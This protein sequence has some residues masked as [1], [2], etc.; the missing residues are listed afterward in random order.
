MKVDDPYVKHMKPGL[1]VF[2]AIGAL[3]PESW[4]TYLVDMEYYKVKIPF[5]KIK[6]PCLM[7]HGDC[8]DDIN[9]S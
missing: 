7:I 6:T 8:D 4:D 9:Y 3:W 5:E 2:V 1:P